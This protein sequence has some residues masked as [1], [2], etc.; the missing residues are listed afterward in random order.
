VQALTR[1]L[2]DE[3][4]VVEVTETSVDDFDGYALTLTTQDPSVM[5]VLIGTAPELRQL[6]RKIDAAIVDL[7]LIA[8]D[9]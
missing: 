6:L 2:I 4:V 5:L 7:D 1:F 9:R 8:S 3:S